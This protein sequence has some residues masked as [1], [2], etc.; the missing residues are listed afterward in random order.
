[1][2]QQQM[3]VSGQVRKF[4]SPVLISNATYAYL[5]SVEVIRDGKTVSLTQKQIIHA[6]ETY[7]LTFVEKDGALVF[8]NPPKANIVAAQ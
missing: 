1:M 6:G 3:K 5:I 4:I 2:N 7:E 8:V